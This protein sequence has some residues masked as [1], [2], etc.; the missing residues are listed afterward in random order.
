MP[1]LYVKQLYILK[2]VM[3]VCNVYNGGYV[4]SLIVLFFCSRQRRAQIS[5]ALRAVDAMSSRF[6]SSTRAS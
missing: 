5:L 4:F 2:T 6:E 3:Y 1:Q